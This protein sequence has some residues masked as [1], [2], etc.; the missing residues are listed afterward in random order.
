MLLQ[1]FGKESD[2][3]FFGQQK[4]YH[5]LDSEVTCPEGKSWK[6]SAI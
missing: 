5:A 4:C 6:I 1:V 2:R 3:F